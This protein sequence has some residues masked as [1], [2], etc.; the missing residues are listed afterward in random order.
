MVRCEA[1]K[2]IGQMGDRDA[3]LP[4]SL[5]KTPSALKPL[6]F[7]STDDNADWSGAKNESPPPA[8]LEPRNRRFG[9]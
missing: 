1:A 6:I 8:R 7:R 2:A 9:T 3:L 4:V 5:L